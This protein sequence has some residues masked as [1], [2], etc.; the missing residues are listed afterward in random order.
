V[1]YGTDWPLASMES[2]LDFMEE[3][4]LPARDKDLMFFENAAALFK[5]E[6]KPRSIGLGSLLRGL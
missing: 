5:L 2:Y 3:L 1:L 6:I 4:N